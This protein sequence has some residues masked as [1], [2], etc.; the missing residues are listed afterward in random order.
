MPILDTLL[1]RA[2]N[3]LGVWT[4][5]TCVPQIAMP[6]TLVLVRHGESVSGVSEKKHIVSLDFGF[7]MFYAHGGKRLKGQDQT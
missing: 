3:N 6:Y 4:P 1:R 7:S 5:Q 2:K